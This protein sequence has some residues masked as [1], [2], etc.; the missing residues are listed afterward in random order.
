MATQ[1]AD[2]IIFRWAMLVYKVQDLSSV[3]VGCVV[4]IDGVVSQDEFDIICKGIWSFILCSIHKYMC[5]SQ[6]A[7]C[8]HLV[9]H[10][11][12]V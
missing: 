8:A 1:V 9:L 6:V 2:V 4:L 12:L 3:V 7:T 10:S 11:I 5:G